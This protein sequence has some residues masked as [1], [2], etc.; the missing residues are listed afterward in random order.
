VTLE[1]IQMKII[2]GEILVGRNQ[3]SQP[4]PPA[5]VTSEPET[6]RK[7]DFEV[8]GYSTERDQEKIF[9]FPESETEIKEYDTSQNQEEYVYDI[10]ELPEVIP[11]EAEPIQDSEFDDLEYGCPFCGATVGAFATMCPSCGHELEEEEDISASPNIESPQQHQTLED[12]YRSQ[13]S[14]RYSKRSGDQPDPY[15]KPNPDLSR[16]DTRPRMEVEPI[17]E[18]TSE[19]NIRLSSYARGMDTESPPLCEF[20]KKPTRYIK[21]YGRWYCFDCKKYSKSRARPVEVPESIR[22]GRRTGGVHQGKPLKDYP[23]YSK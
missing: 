15:Y 4:G 14:G 5:E 23:R 10:D 8:V 3:N 7:E 2:S 20:C 1:Q 9:T 16:S 22:N 18:S 11:V 13:N 17:T 19:S 21:E 12:Y 6:R